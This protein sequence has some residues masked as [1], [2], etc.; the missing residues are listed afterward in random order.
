MAPQAM[1]ESE[2]AQ[3]FLPRENPSVP[4]QRHLEPVD[5]YQAAFAA[6]TDATMIWSEFW[7]ETGDGSFLRNGYVPTTEGAIAWYICKFPWTEI[8]S[9]VGTLTVTMEW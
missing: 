1:L 3:R 7:D 6:S 5:P 9:E 4:G 2:W 8:T